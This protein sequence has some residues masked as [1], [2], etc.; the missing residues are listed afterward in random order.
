MGPSLRGVNLNWDNI[1]VR[2]VSCGHDCV[3]SQAVSRFFAFMA[4]ESTNSRFGS[5]FK[6]TVKSTKGMI[7]DALGNVEDNA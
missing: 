1:E 2:K 6:R 4:V 5:V 7:G 3:V